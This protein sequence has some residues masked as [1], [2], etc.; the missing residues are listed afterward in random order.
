MPEIDG[1][2][3]DEEFSK[4]VLKLREFW[5]KDDMGSRPPCRTCGSDHFF[6]HPA[7]L[8]NRSDTVS[9]MSAHT[10]FPCVAVYCGNCGLVD[11]YSARILGIEVLQVSQP[12]DA[13]GTSNG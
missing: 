4:V 3:K 5:S 10:R 12:G 1:T 7:L 9:M 13:G 6:I 11:M 8:G 2:L